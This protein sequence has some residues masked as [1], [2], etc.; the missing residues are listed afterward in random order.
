MRQHPVQ[1]VRLLARPVTTRQRNGLRRKNPRTV[2]GPASAQ[3]LGEAEHV[4]RRRDGAD[5][6]HF[7][8]LLLERAV[9]SEIA[10]AGMRGPDISTHV[11]NDVSCLEVGAPPDSRVAHRERLEQILPGK[12]AK[13]PVL[14][15]GPTH[16]LAQQSL[17][18]QRRIGDMLARGLGRMHVLADGRNDLLQPIDAHPRPRRPHH[19]Q[20][21]GVRHQMEHGDLAAQATAELR[22]HLR[23]P[24]RE[25]KPSKLD[26]PQR[27][28]VGKRLGDGED[29]EYRIGA[30]RPLPLRVLR[31]DRCAQPDT[32]V[33]GNGDHRTEVKLPRYVGLDH[34]AQMLEPLPT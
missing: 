11:G 18:R 30:Q 12:V 3:H 33:A 21:R 14:R 16:H 34:R 19:R 31:T 4:G 7:G 2:Q 27:Q 6:G 22:N 17:V 8:V 29:A 10:V 25:R 5:P 15:I 24:A 20:P 23:D 1:L 32:S 13:G 28:H 9:R 26:R